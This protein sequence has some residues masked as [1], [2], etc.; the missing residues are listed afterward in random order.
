M[1]VRYYKKNDYMFGS[2]KICA[3]NRH[4]PKGGY[5]VYK[6]IIVDDEEEIRQGLS[7]F[8]GWDELGFLLVASFE[9][10]KDAIEYLQNN[11]VDVILTDILMAQVSGIELAEYVYRNKPNINVVII[12]GHKEFEYAKKAIEFNVETY[13]LKPTDI[14]EIHK[15]FTE[16]R[17]KLD[18]KNEI[19]LEQKKLQNKYQEVL[20]MLEEKFFT[21]LLMGGISSDNMIEQRIS[22]IG[23]DLDLDSGPCIIAEINLTDYQKN[24][25]EK[26]MHGKERLHIAIKNIFRFSKDD[27]QYFSIFNETHLKIIIIASNKMAIEIMY[28]SVNQYLKDI[29][30]SI[31]TLLGVN[32]NIHIAQCFKSLKEISMH[33]EPLKINKA[34]EAPYTF[35]PEVYQRLLQ[36]Y[37]LFFS[38]INDGDRDTLMSLIDTYMDEIDE[39]P[40]SFVH[41]LIDDLFTI[42]LNKFHEM[43]LKFEDNAF[44]KMHYFS[45]FRI[46]NMEDIRTSIRERFSSILY[47]VSSQKRKTIDFSVDQAIAYIAKNFYKDISLEDVS[48]EVFLNSVY[49][50]R[51]FKQQTGENFTDY[52]TKMRMEKAIEL[53]EMKKY[54]IYEISEMV[55]Y[56]SSKY[57]SRVFKLYCGYT[58]KDYVKIKDTI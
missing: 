43:G 50:S 58:P 11:D 38:V 20:P 1:T 37:K 35:E 24:N 48:N 40:I 23:L 4:V 28:S 8:I 31:K 12:S 36:K 3:K 42:L 9:D 47:F 2:D 29:Q 27:M 7:D 10:G 34:H 53:V 52:L 16:L 13:L 19:R 14:D 15:S 21:D 56:S 33:R 22:S 32:L 6:L 26:F 55:G 17:K 30:E 44:S 18:L 46:Y 57:F 25:G 49:F 45:I 54:K 41:R 39:L 51:L 5:L